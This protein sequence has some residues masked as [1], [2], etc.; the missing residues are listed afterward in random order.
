MRGKL[1]VI[2]LSLLAVTALGIGPASAH[3]NE[4]ELVNEA[5][6]HI[7]NGSSVVMKSTS[8]KMHAWNQTCGWVELIGEVQG[9]YNGDVTLQ[10]ITVN[11]PEFCL[12]NG[13]PVSHYDLEVPDDFEVEEVPVADEIVI[14]PGGTGFFPWRSIATIGQNIRCTG[15]GMMD[16]AWNHS[17]GH[18]TVNM[19]G[20]LEGGG[21]AG[22]PMSFEESFGGE[23]HQYNP[24]TGEYGEAVDFHE[25]P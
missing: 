17:S 13:M 12:F 9:S 4:V 2:V 19:S 1:S 24:G 8:F 7:Q 5:G 10:N 6:T 25:I 11:T 18:T 23:F 16:L 22:C 3:A 15:Q 21:T 14:E 20:L